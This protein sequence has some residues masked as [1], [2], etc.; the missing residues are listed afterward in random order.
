M[1]FRS[2]FKTIR[3]NSKEPGIDKKKFDE[4]KRKG[5]LNL[6][7]PLMGEKFKQHPKRPRKTLKNLFQ[8]NNIPP[9][10]RKAPV[11]YV[12]EEPLVVAGVGISAD[13]ATCTG[14]RISPQWEQSD[15][16]E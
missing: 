10:Q 12:G 2:I 4:V 14:P 15:V 13:W 9:W 11:L 7:D 3:A 16:S 6:M 1:L 5:L 8:E